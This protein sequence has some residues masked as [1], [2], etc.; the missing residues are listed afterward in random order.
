MEKKSLIGN[1]DSNISPAGSLTMKPLSSI[2]A[3]GN[4]IID[5][6]AEIDEEIINRYHLKKGEITFMTQ[7][8]ANFFNEIESKTQVTF[9]TGGAVQN[10][11]RIA[12]WCLNKDPN[13]KNQN[14]KLTML[15]SVGND[16]NKDRIINSLKF[17]GVNPLLQV[18]PNMNTSRCAIGVYKNERCLVP[19]IKASN[20]L[21]ENFINENAQEILSHEV[22]II[23]GYFLKE[24]YDLCKK[25]CEEFIKLNKYIILTLCDPFM[26]EFHEE[27]IMDIANYA[28]MIVGNVR[29]TEIMAKNT[30]NGVQEIFENIHKKLTKKNRLLLVTA[31]CQGAFCTSF[32]YETNKLEFLIQDFPQLIK[33]NDIVDDVG[34][35]EAFFG[36]FLSQQM[37]G[38]KIKSCCMCGN[39]I[40]NV[41]L[42]NVGCTFPNDTTIDFNY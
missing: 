40:A 42:R 30:G 19:D 25:I 36:G 9:S 4:P 20:Y 11:L 15:G 1:G 16:I 28:D 23:E 3:I 27:K 6:T 26:I 14:Q 37:Q 31:G 22:L 7:E 10:S 29:T 39:E 5:I 13:N 18:I 24:K 2:I 34:A 32:N 8:N 17:Y 35:R 21:T 33:M 41:I 12:S 38:K